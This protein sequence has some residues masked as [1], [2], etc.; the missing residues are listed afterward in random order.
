MS[1]EVSYLLIGVVVGILIDA[2]LVDWWVK[3]L[4]RRAQ[5]R[6]RRP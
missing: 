2:L 5:R 6:E 1:T 3:H 4:V